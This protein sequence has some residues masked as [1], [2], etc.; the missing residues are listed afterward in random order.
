MI[1]YLVIK[2]LKRSFFKLRGI[3]TFRKKFSLKW[4]EICYYTTTILEKLTL[5]KD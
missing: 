1:F 3:A 5:F 2:N 4:H